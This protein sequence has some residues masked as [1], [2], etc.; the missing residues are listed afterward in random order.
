MKLPNF[1]QNPFIVIWELTRA[2][3]LKCLHCRAEAQYHRHPL[4]LSFEEGKAL[5]DEIYEM[6]NPMLVFSGGDPLMRPDVFALAD[7]AT[8]KGVRLSMTPSAT[9]NVTKQAIER[10]KEVGLAR[11]AFSLD[12]PTAKIHDHFRGTEGSFALTM[13]AISYL[14]ELNVPIQINTVISRY[15]YET[16][17]EMATLVERLGC[18][19]W[20][21]FFLVP[22]GRGKESDMIA[23]VEHEKTFLWL[24][25][26]SKRSSFDIKTTA[27]QHY[28]RVVIQQKMKESTSGDK[29]IR[30]KDVLSEGHTGK[31]DGLGR[32]PKGVNDGNGF[33]FISHIGDVYPSGLLPVKCGNVRDTPIAE[34]YR[35]S[36]ILKQLRT[37]DNYKGKC[38]ICEFRYVCGGSRSRAYAMTGDYLESDPFCIYIPKALR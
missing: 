9:E 17:E 31:I 11:W 32:A 34:I 19:L 1:N 37:P 14:Q 38:G 10:A 4:E 26:L 2:C 27:A 6:D 8:Q 21:V 36:P 5:I 18:V 28:R 25:E 22:T 12:G 20:S 23:P 33:V 24:Y 7:Y 3:E 30:Y 29:S 35:E 15:N 16:L 13:K